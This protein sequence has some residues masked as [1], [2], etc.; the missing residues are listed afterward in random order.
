MAIN[1][2]TIALIRVLHDRSTKNQIAWE[3]TG[4]PN[5]Y[6]AS[7]P[8]YSIVLRLRKPGE[9]V[10]QLGNEEGDLIEE[11]SSELATSEIDMRMHET[12]EFARR[13]ALGVD[14]ALDEILKDFGEKKPQ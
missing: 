8:K 1:D 13:R 14:E 3:K 6:Q 7:L 11:Y 4:Q 12:Y 2:K 5:A 10:L 9:V